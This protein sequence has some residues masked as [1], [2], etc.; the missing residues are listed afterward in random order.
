MVLARLI[1]VQIIFTD[2]KIMEIMS[3]A[4]SKRTAHDKSLG[5][6]HF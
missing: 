5:D 1:N 4:M 3:T 2:T 6:T